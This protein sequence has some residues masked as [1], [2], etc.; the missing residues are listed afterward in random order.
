MG[1]QAAT[2]RPVLERGD[3]AAEIGFAPRA[4]A[5]R[6][7]HLYQRAPCR[8]LAPRS[9]AGEPLQAVLVTTS[10]GLADGDRLSFALA[11]EAGVTA[12]ATTQAAEKIYRAHGGDPT[13]VDVALTV[14]R[15]AW[16]EWL[17]QETILFEGARLVRCAR[18]GV[19]AGGRLLACEHVVFGR[20]AR[21]ERFVRG[22]LFDRWEVRRD[23]RLVWYDALALDGGAH[24]RAA[25]WG[26][27][28]AEALATALYVAD[29]APAW[30]ERAR[31]IFADVVPEGARGAATVVNGLLVT[32]FLGEAVAVRAGLGRYLADFRAAV[33]G[34]APT[35]P[36][37]WAI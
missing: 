20:L 14:A 12:Q 33:G 32:R 13:R 8:V 28:G 9:P 27:A 21:G 23:G 17:P 18:T 16:F 37:V 3:G 7:V 1:G 31:A 34:F 11:A 29:D 36:R 4:G 6:L 22:H 26:F 19:A 2:T 30:L 35:L 5:T 10:G 15:G 25:A 24:A